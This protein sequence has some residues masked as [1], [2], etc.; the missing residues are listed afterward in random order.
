M[1]FSIFLVGGAVIMYFFTACTNLSQGPAAAAAVVK[2]I[3]LGNIT[4]NKA[5]GR[6]CAN[7]TEERNHCVTI[8]LAWPE[9]KDGNV[10][11]QQSV[12]N[13][14]RQ[15]LVG[16][17]MPAAESTEM[18]KLT[19]EAA[20]QGLL[21]AHAEWSKESPDGMVG[22]WSVETSD[23][24]LLN[25]GKLLTLQLNGNSYMGG[26]HGS[27]VVY[28]ATFDVAT[29][30]R[31]TWDDLVTDKAQMQALAERKFRE[32]QPD[33]F[34]SES[35]GGLGYKFDEVF[36]FKLADSYGITDKGL[37]MLYGH[38]EVTPYAYGI[39]EF[40]IPFEELGALWKWKQ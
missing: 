22:Q 28:V 40:V 5:D 13:W 1:R 21:D 23:T 12:T 24:V 20:A 34:K 19:V 18:D 15:F 17:L 27:T 36:P 30:K 31:L 38:Y 7:M 37:Y 39:T 26:A 6:D 4:Y 16:M 29:G 3:T 25:N 11:L 2:P 32:V 35:E 14:A 8:K 10:P 33:F 9:V